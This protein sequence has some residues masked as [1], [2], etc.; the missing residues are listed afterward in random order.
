VTG[1]TGNTTGHP[2][3]DSFSDGQVALP[4]PTVTLC[5]EDE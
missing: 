3:T 1:A 4:V 5:I 2:L